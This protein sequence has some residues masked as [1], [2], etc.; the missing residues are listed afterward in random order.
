M[1][2]LVEKPFSTHPCVKRM[3][4]QSSCLMWSDQLRA[5]LWNRPEVL[6]KV[7]FLALPMLLH[8][9]T[10]K[11]LGKTRNL[12]QLVSSTAVEFSITR[13]SNS[14]TIRWSSRAVDYSQRQTS[15]LQTKWTLTTREWLRKCTMH[16]SI[17]SRV[18]LMRMWLVESCKHLPSLIISTESELSPLTISQLVRLQM[19]KEMLRA[20]DT[21]T[22][23][24]FLQFQTCLNR[25]AVSLELEAR[26][27]FH[28]VL[29]ITEV[30]MKNTHQKNLQLQLRKF[31]DKLLMLKMVKTKEKVSDYS[32]REV[33]WA[34]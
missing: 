29:S 32:I 11:W 17:C 24:Y 9:T 27:I 28:T 34:E 3:I 22:H 1:W 12:P 30:V 13:L 33:K 26:T 6:L 18:Q 10:N 25:L 23:S 8:T 15:Q 19:S 20:P 7:C 5:T 14:R 2:P 31:W 16:S 21:E 4:A